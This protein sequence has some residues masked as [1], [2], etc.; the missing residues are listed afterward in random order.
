MSGDQSN[1]DE[2]DPRP[3]EVSGR[4]FAICFGVILAMV[5]LLVALACIIGVP[6]VDG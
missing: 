3:P 5:G 4:V 2:F 1:D 6:F